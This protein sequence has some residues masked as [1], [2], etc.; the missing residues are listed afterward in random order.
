MWDYSRGA[1]CLGG[2]G[3]KD[4]PSHISQGSDWGQEAW[5][6]HAELGGG[7]GSDSLCDVGVY[8]GAM[9]VRQW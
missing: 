9:G 5:D 8:R 3:H 4:H 1:G 7:G 6:V 2:T